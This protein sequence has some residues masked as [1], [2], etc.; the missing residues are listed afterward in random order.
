MDW[1]LKLDIK[2][3]YKRQGPQGVSA[4]STLGQEFT[5]GPYTSCFSKTPTVADLACLWPEVA[6]S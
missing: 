3:E 4:K 2:M 6:D 1:L 5:F